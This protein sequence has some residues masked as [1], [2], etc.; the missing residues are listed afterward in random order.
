MN[1]SPTIPRRQIIPVRIYTD[2]DE[3][4][5]HHHDLCDITPEQAWAETV[6]LTDWL[7]DQVFNG[8]RPQWVHA[9]DCDAHTWARDRMRRL[10]SIRSRR[11][12]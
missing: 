11:A 6:K 5:V 12:A 4:R 3:A 7:S 10:G 8:L 9:A 2:R 1:D